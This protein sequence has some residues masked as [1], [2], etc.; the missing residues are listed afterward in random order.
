VNQPVYTANT[1]RPRTVGV[2]VQYR[3]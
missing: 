1:F 2:T 3:Y